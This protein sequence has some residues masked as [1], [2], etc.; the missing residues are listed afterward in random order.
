MQ[1]KTNG[2]EN[3]CFA[4]EWSNYNQNNNNDHEYC[5]D[6]I[7]KACGSWPYVFT[8]IG[9]Y[10]AVYIVLIEKGIL[11]GYWCL[12]FVW[13]HSIMGPMQGAVVN[14]CGHKYGY[15]NFDTPDKSKNMLPWDLIL[16]GELLQNNHHRNGSDP[17]LASK[18]WEL[19]PTYPVMKVMD[20]VGIIKLK[21][22]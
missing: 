14:W 1:Y 13:L 16:M 6:F 4:L 18:W 19:D 5:W 12:A 22:A 8:M 11:P 7:D 17:N 9:S 15:R 10:V 2:Y 3:K 20:F 21:S